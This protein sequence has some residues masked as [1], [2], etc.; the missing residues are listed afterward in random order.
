M[1]KLTVLIVLALIAAGGFA[2]ESAGPIE[3]DE[4]LLFGSTD[5]MFSEPLITDAEETGVDIT[6]LLL[7]SERDVTGAG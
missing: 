7:V 3:T 6:S 5:G 2:Q 4:D 1:N